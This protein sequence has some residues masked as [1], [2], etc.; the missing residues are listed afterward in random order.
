VATASSTITINDTQVPVW[1]TALGSLDR[2]LECSDAAG[3]TAAQALAPQATDQCDPSLTITKTSGTFVAGT[4]PQSGTYT[5]T[6]IATDDCLNKSVVF[7]QTITIQDLTIPV[8]TTTPGSLNASFDCSDLS[9]I[10][11]AQS[12]MPAATDN[13]DLSLN[14]VKTA[15]TFVPNP[16]CAGAGTYTNTFIAT[17]D[18]GNSTAQ[19]VQVI[20]ITDNNAPVIDTPAQNASTECSSNNIADLNAWIANHGGAVASDVCSGVLTWTN[21]IPTFNPGCGGT[22]TYTV[23]FTV[24]DNC[25]NNASTTATFTI[26]DTQDP[27]ITCPANVVAQVDLNDCVATG[28]NLGTPVTNDACSAVTVTNDAPVAFPPGVTIVTWT[29]TDECGNSATCTQT[30]TVEDLL[31][32]SVICPAD[33]APVNAAAGQCSAFVTVPSPNVTDP[34]PYTITNDFNNTANASGTY[35]VGVTTVTWTITGISGVSATCIQLV[36]VIDAQAPTIVCPPNVLVTAPAPACTLQVI[37]ILPPTLNDNCDPLALVLTWTKTGAT[38]GT[39]TGDVNNTI[40]NVGVTTVEYRVTDLSGNFATCTFTVTVNDQVPPTVI[41]CPADITVN[42]DAGSCFA[43]ITI[44]PLN[45]VDPCG[46]IVSIIND[47]NGTNNASGQYP[48]GTTTVTWTIT[49]ASGNV[50]LCVHDVT[51]NDTQFPTLTCPPDAIDLITNNGCNMIPGTIGNPTY[52]DNCAVV[53]LT[54]QKTGA[55]T[56]NSAATGINL[57]NGTLFNVG[58]TIVTYTAYDA[59]GNSVSCT[60]MV[61]I[62]NLNAPQFHADCPVSPV[63]VNAGVNCNTFV[64]VPGPVI[65]NPCNELYTVTNTSPYKTSDA[66]ASGTYPPGT[67]TFTW[68]IT[69]ASG[70]I[71]TCTQSV[72]VT[73]VTPPTLAC[74]PDAIDLI[75]NGGC[76]MVPGTIGNPTYSDNCGVVTLTWAMTGATTGNSANTGINLVNSQVFNVGQTFVTYTAYDAAGNSVSCTLMVWIKNL[77]APQFSVACPLAVITVNA[78]VN[79]STYVAVPSPA[80]TN[81]CNEL[82]TM[83]NTSPFKTSDTDASGTYPPGTTSFVWTI[84]DASGNITTCP[85]SVTVTDVT[86][87][88]LSCPPDAIDEITNGGCNMVPANIGLPTYGDNC[89]VVTLR[90]AMSGATVGVSPATG[91]NTVN[92]QLFNVGQTF[93][94]YTAYDAAGNFVSCTFMVWVKSLVLPE[95]KVTCPVETVSAN[96]GANCNAFVTVPAP[97]IENP[98]NELY[99]ITNTSP[100]K[101]SDANAS[102]TYPVGTTSFEWTIT[103]ASGTV[104]ICPQSVTVTDVTAPSLTCPL[105][106]ID[107]I[108]NG[109][110]NMVPAT[111]G[112]PVFADN[113][114]VV[115][116]RWAMTGATTGVSPASG[117]NYVNGQLFNVGQTIVTYIVFDAAG[118]S[119]SCTFM[120]WIKNLDAPLFQ[121]E[122]PVETVEEDAGIDCDAF[123][124][125]PGPV[126]TNPCN[127]LFTVF[128]DSPHK[129]SDSDASGT[130]PTGTTTFTWTITDASGNITTCPQSVTVTDNMAPSLTCPDDA[131]DEIVNGGCDMVPGTIGDPVYSDNCDGGDPNA[132]LTLTW[133]MFGATTGISGATGINVVNGQTFNVGITRVLYTLTDQSGNTDTCSFYVWIKSLQD[134]EFEVICPASP[135]TVS[136]NAGSCDAYVTVPPPTIINPCGEDYKIS[137]DSP[138]GIPA[139]GLYDVGTTLITWEIIDAS[140]T[141]I[142]CSQNII[143]VD[144]VDPL[145]TCPPS[146]VVNADFELPYATGIVLGIP[147]YSDN[148]D[149]LSLTWVHSA[150]TPGNSPL[151]GI[152]ID[153]TSTFNAGVTTITYT[154]T[155]IHGNVTTC[156]FTITVLSE[157]V[158]LC[159]ADIN[160]TTDLGYCSATLDPGGPTKV[161]GVEPIAW[162]YTIRDQGNFIIG[163]GNCTTATIATCIGEFEFPVGTNTITWTATNVSGTTECVQTIIVVDDEPPTYTA[164]VPFER[165]VNQIITAQYDGVPEPGAGIIPIDPAHGNPRRPD[166]YLVASGST[167]LDLMGLSDNCCVP[168]DINISWTIDYDPTTGYASISGT[169]QPSLSTPIYLWGIYTNVNVT[170]TITYIISDCNGNTAQP[171]IRNL[172]ITPRPD[173]I[174]Q[175]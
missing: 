119:T 80:I 21:T 87:P 133:Q 8:W 143:V 22:G 111:I 76:N 83:V 92:G 150:T 155:D 51:V 18:C 10:A 168:A 72:I 101:T 77:N 137:N 144:D 29:A 58:Q 169:G 82:Y 99:T 9:G 67:T 134:P 139:D 107:E 116:L 120:V 81:P 75:I 48:A 56:G 106:A 17:D 123:V 141:K 44:P 159:P 33:P 162:T 13:C 40:F 45:V 11:A 41:N 166:W 27:T 94:T 149:I 112:M 164:P 138:Y 24:T 38:T 53:T 43:N 109:G 34:C 26:V 172:L 68:T 126:I 84:T 37:N 108:T 97:G 1:A 132:T 78:S 151:T 160:T 121:A 167:E 79:C 156:S 62:K 113:C 88:T 71:T 91:I 7:T 154:L 148:C 171:I 39:G 64:T 165:C 152:N 161:S 146:Q 20:T 36:T 12:L 46:E 3:L 66:D 6:F 5:N 42:A 54:W 173:I 90:W 136:A 55:T 174:K 15:G 103:D 25:N 95:F 23:T 59:S 170:H 65:T 63:S 129:T 127:E 105:D 142:Y 28:V 124:T 4:C 60:F 157:P 47:F 85:Q 61:W 118:N 30:V 70:N 114:G 98:C 158:I 57:V 122:C 89:G 102:G 125:V 14:I 145:L 135:I 96:A 86:P 31:P 147:A 131:I 104:T 16:T 19:F 93:V 153:N 140:G 73:D 117:I 32:P 74:P 50:T 49:D 35:P 69:D 2:T 110:C 163:S 52:S 128:N 100:Y 130:Y 175:Y 115:T